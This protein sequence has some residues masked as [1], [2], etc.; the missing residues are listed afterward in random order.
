MAVD[1]FQKLIQCLSTVY[2]EGDV[3]CACAGREFECL[4]E[5]AAAGGDIHDILP[6]IATHLDC[7]PD[8]R[9][10]FEALVAMVRAEN[11]PTT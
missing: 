8:C 7:C 4:A 5:Q 6:K 10:E 3:D 11:P 2:S 9:E 1:R